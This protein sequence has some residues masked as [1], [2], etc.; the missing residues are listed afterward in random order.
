M[1]TGKKS[2]YTRSALRDRKAQMKSRDL[3]VSL[4]WVRGMTVHLGQLLARQVE[5]DEY[6]RSPMKHRGRPNCSRVALNFHSLIS[7][8]RKAA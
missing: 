8:I 3:Q 6:E 7:T 1:G 2:T 4:Q 5:R